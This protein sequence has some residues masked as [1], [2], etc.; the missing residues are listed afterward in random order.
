[1]SDVRAEQHLVSEQGKERERALLTSSERDPMATTLS[2]GCAPLTLPVT[3]THTHSLC[4]H[5]CHRA[6]AWHAQ[7]LSALF[8]HRI[9]IAQHTHTHPTSS[10]SSGRHAR[11]RPQVALSLSRCCP[12]PSLRVLCPRRAAPHGRGPA[13]KTASVVGSARALLCA[14]GAV[15][16]PR[17]AAAVAPRLPADHARGSVWPGIGTSTRARSSALAKGCAQH[18]LCHAWS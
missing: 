5:S 18:V 9:H 8:R 10:H 12:P 14:L 17:A 11:S 1:M 6:C 4:H 7:P 15:L 16:W 13:P 2:S 3:H